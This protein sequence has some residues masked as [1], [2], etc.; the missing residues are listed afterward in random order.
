MTE[1]CSFCDSEWGVDP[2]KDGNGYRFNCCGSCWAHVLNGGFTPQ[3]IRPRIQIER[4]RRRLS[5]IA[6]VQTHQ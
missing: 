1:K 2:C 4:Q 3:D 6:E 5:P